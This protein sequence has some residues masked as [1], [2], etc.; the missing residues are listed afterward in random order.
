MQ[1]WLRNSTVAMV[2][3]LLIAGFAAAQ[4]IP[5]ADLSGRVSDAD[6]A[7][8]PGVTVEVSSPALQGVRLATTDGNGSYIFKSLP[9]GEYTVKFT[10]EGFEEKAFA[11]KLSAAQKSTLD[12]DMSLSAVTETIT[13]TGESV[14]D[15]SQNVTTATTL[16]QQTLE[17]LPL[18]R[19]QLQAVAMAAGTAATGPAGQITISGAQSWENSYQINGVEVSDNLRR[20]PFTLF[21]EDAIEETTT[22]TAGISAEYGRFTGGLVNTVT[23]SGG[24]EF[25]GSLRDNLTN[26]SWNGENRFSP[27]PVDEIQEVYE[28]TFGGRIVRDKLWFFAAGRAFDT[29]VTNTTQ[30]LNLPWEATRDQKRYEGKLTYSPSS[31]HRFTGSYIEI[32]D[33]SVTGHGGLVNY[34]VDLEALHDRSTPQ[35]LLAIN[36]SGV[37]TSNFFVEAQYSER[38]FNFEPEG[39]SDTSLLGGTPI[40]DQVNVLFFNESIFC[41]VCADGGDKRENENL[42]AKASYFLSTE[43][44]GSH[45]LVFGYDTYDDIRTSNNYQSTTN[46]MFYADDGL[47]VDNVPYPVAVSA[48]EGGASLVVYYP[49]LLPT[50][51]TSFKTNSIFANDRWRLNDQ[52]SFNV[53]VRYDQNDGQD[54]EGKKVADDSEFSPRLGATWA[55]NDDWTFNASYG[56]YIAAIANTIADASS[57]A[58]SAATYWWLYDGPSINVGGPLVSSEDALATVFDWFNSV[59]GVNNTDYLVLANIPG[60]SLIIGD[61][62]KSTSADEYVVG[63]LRNFSGRGSLRVDLVHREFGNFYATQRDLSTGQVTDPN[64]NPVDLGIIV[65]DDTVLKRE[66]NGLQSAFNY[67]LNDRFSFGGNYTLSE[68]K[69]NFEGENRGSGPVTSIEL[70]YPEYKDLSWNAPEG[71]LLIDSTHKLALWAIWEAYKSD[72]QRIA[73]SALQRFFSGTAYSAIGPVGS[74]DYVVNPGYES[75]PASVNYFFSDRGEFTTDD[76]LSTD[77]GLNYSFFLGDVELYAQADITNVFNDDNAILVNQAVFTSV[78]DPS[79]E[80]F[81]PFTEIPVE[82]VH[83]RR[84]ANFG[85]PTSV[86][87]VQL[88]RT[89]TLSLGIRF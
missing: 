68:S 73:I 72:R 35:D 79:L 7:A 69:G 48:S 76:I 84:G 89:Y 57:S 77:I 38:S 21:I 37:L 51:G 31:N 40:L 61:D 20:Q 66:Y 82:G 74:S 26:Q 30:F 25:H 12:V 17:E 87:D 86:N 62:L 22:S 42:L 64:G 75:P 58:G 2:A 44:L 32:E 45:D 15:I 54:A 6:G 83:W 27:E 43:G 67:R 23:K 88:P 34:L 63:F 28:G 41:G 36:Y 60:G 3:G 85:Q 81:N 59:G 1:R 47:Y 14:T 52:W 39:G 49:I 19:T 9:A 70:S 56:R 53:G 16:A 80:P 24:N 8:V 46:F 29:A 4:G 78:N 71:K 11:R 55:P 13:V 33:T 10:L 65:N 50:K 18:P 5:T